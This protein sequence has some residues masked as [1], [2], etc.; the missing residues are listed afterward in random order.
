[1]NPHTSTRHKAVVSPESESIL[2]VTSRA[3][4]PACARQ[5]PW[6]STEACKS[7][8]AKLDCCH[9]YEMRL[10]QRVNRLVDAA[11]TSRSAVV[12]NALG[13]AVMSAQHELEAVRRHR[14]HLER[15]VPD[16]LEPTTSSAQAPQVNPASGD[17]NASAGRPGGSDV[18]A[19]NFRD[20]AAQQ[21]QAVLEIIGQERRAVE[22]QFSIPGKPHSGRNR[23][24][25][26]TR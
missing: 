16:G 18:D 23:C 7:L 8:S 6:D 10:D 3:H 1:M 24:Y 17:L 5:A 15:L 2:D 11:L 4:G 26:G 13:R 21:A 9:D 14:R 19:R 22:A 25:G 20:A 12:R